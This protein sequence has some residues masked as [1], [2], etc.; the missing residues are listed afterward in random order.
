MAAPST[1]TNSAF[2]IA[3]SH[4]PQMV[5][6]MRKQRHARRALA[7]HRGDVVDRAHGRRRAGED[8]RERPQRLADAGR[9]ER[10]STAADRPVQPALAA[11]IG[12]EPRGDERR[13]TRRT[14]VQNDSMFSVGNDM[15]RAPICSGM[16]KLPKAPM[17]IGVMAKKIMMVPCM[18]NSVV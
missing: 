13:S 5:S 6:G 8:E 9:A 14:C 15:S 2:R 16:Q 3:V 7:Q 4:R 12:H 11:P 18:V 1:G 10:A 17:R